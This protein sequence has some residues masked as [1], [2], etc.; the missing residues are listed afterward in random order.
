MPEGVN[1]AAIGKNL[2]VVNVVRLHTHDETSNIEINTHHGPLGGRPFLLR[3]PLK[4]LFETE[5]HFKPETKAREVSMNRVFTRIVLMDSGRPLIEARSTLEFFRGLHNAFVSKS[6]LS[7][8][9]S[10][11]KSLTML[12]AGHG[13]LYFHNHVLHRDIS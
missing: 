2:K 13:T 10:Y 4:D 6:L 12:L 8:Q 3:D 11:R 5:P 1:L 9:I 7:H